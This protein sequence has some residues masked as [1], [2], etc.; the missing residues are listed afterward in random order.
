MRIARPFVVGTLL[1]AARAAPARADSGH[2][3]DDLSLRLASAFTRFSEVSAFGGA[4]VANRWSTAMNPATTGWPTGPDRF[5]SVIAGC[6]S[7]IELDAGST[8]DVFGET[9]SWAR[10]QRRR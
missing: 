9:G 1:L 8:V 4:T 6:R 3:G 10:T 7:S 2:E 5:R